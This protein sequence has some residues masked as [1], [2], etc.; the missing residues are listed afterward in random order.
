MK[1]ISIRDNVWSLIFNGKEISRSEDKTLNVVIVGATEHISRIYYTSDYNQSDQ[2]KPDCYSVDGT[3]P[4]PSVQNAQSLTCI[5][6]DKNI[7]GSGAG[8]SK[9]CKFQQRIAVVLAGD[10][11]GNVYALNIPSK[12]IFGEGELKKWPLQAYCKKLANN[13]APITSVVTEMCLHKDSFGSRI[14][15]QPTKIL[16]DDEFK[17]A[18][19]QS[20]SIATKEAIDVSF[21]T[22]V[23]ENNLDITSK[24]NFINV[25]R[26]MGMIADI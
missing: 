19:K 26:A 20:E 25:A 23:N 18:L 3:K 8:S 1:R 15:F 4:H 24:E 11:E 5:G 12:S 2:R 21:E 14:T 10:I 6:C 13:G 7:K 16:D 9:A 17:K 22:H